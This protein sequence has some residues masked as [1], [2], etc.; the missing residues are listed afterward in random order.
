M[1]SKAMIS[2]KKMT[3]TDF[4]NNASSREIVATGLSGNEIYCMNLKGFTAGNLVIGNSVYSLGLLRGIAAGLRSIAG[5]EITEVTN[6]IREGRE[7]SYSRLID[8]A[9]KFGGQGI[10]GVSSELIYHFGNI[11][12]LSIGSTIHKSNTSPFSTSADGQE[13]Y[14]QID[15][16]FK[17]VRFAFGNVAY[18]IGLGG[19]IFGI[20]RSLVRGE[21]K[22]FSDIFNKTRNLALKRIKEDAVAAGANSV[23]GIKTTILPF[24]AMQEMLMLGTASFHPSLSEYYSQNPITSDLT[25][26]EMWNM[27]NLGYMPVELVLGVSVY[28]IG[29]IGGIFSFLRSFVKGEVTELT[30]L[31]YEARENAISKV[32]ANAKAAGADRVVG[33]KTYVYE[34][35]NGMI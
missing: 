21:V 17:P 28:S 35:G 15:C 25:N 16:G 20:L 8:E 33:L 1:C 11:E 9:K 4:Q 10:T 26:E 19:S 3:T 13:L 24:M 12:F 18:S 6:L 34:I 23:V 7:K 29:V 30:E 27:I 31:I 5:G 14:C 32:M 22:E 2:G